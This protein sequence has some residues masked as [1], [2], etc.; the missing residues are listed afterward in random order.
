MAGLLFTSCVRIKGK[1]VSAGKSFYRY[2]NGGK[3]SAGNGAVSAAD[4]KEIDVDWVSGDIRLVCG[5]GKDISF[6]ESFDGNLTEDQL[7][8]WYLDGST[9]RIKYQK[10]GVVNGD[11]KRKS[12]EVTLPKGMVLGKVG[13]ASVSSDVLSEASAS[14]YRVSTVSGDFDLSASV[15]GSVRMDTVSGDCNFRMPQCPSEL[16]VNSVSGSVNLWIPSSSGFTAELQSV[17]GKISCAIPSTTAGGKL[18]A[19]DGSARIRLSSVSG[20]L[21][22][23]SY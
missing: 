5:N 9:L 7:L 19:G 3:Y 10:S 20:D 8:H 14:E 13:I 22:I 12:L 18:T 23:N 4:V 15:S 2:D 6:S 17:S 11:G 21:N 1:S 16:N